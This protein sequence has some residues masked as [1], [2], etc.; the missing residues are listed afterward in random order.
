M[1]KKK[2]LILSLI[3][4]IIIAFGLL[5]INIIRSNK[6]KNS[7][8]Q[9]MDNAL[10]NFQYYD[11]RIDLIDF[12]QSDRKIVIYMT[13]EFDSLSRIEKHIFVDGEF[14]N[15]VRKT[16]KNWISEDKK[17]NDLK[18]NDLTFMD[19]A[20]ILRHNGNDYQYGIY[21][22]TPNGYTDL[23]YSFVDKDGT[24]YDYID[25]ADHKQKNEAWIEGQEINQT[26]RDEIEK[27][28]NSDT[29]NV[30]DEN[31]KATC[32]V[33]A[34]EV[35]LEHLKSPSTAKFPTYNNN[36]I[37]YLYSGNTYTVFGYV[38]AQNSFGA[39]IRT[40]FCVVME[41][42]GVGENAKF[43]AKSYEIYE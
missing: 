10:Q 9:D 25:E 42:N 14:G 16:F 2:I 38:D 29:L 15:E 37:E 22:T 1:K 19:I 3:I 21:Y 26:V 6:Y 35:V 43:T 24:V 20:I 28:E 12:M 4:I 18:T 34:Q 27:E 11:N 32:W 17:Y 30:I 23:K 36:D 40:N 8:I 7:I 31:E 33:L 13:E 39:T 5:I 41:K